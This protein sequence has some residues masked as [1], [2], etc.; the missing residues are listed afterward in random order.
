MFFAKLHPLLVHFPMALL[1]SGTLFQLFGGIQKDETILTAGGFNIYFGF[2]TMFIVMIVGGLALPDLEVEE[3]LAKDFLS[4]HIRYAFFILIT[5]A[6]WIV[7]QKFRGKLWADA[8]HYLLLAFGMATVV[9]TGFYG[10][11]LV[12]RFGFPSQTF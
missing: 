3:D 6:T 12:Y 10:G 5:F 8:A 11:E 1:F 9:M 2:W 7:L 4:S